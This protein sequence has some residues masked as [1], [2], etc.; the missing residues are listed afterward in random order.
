MI[1][2]NGLSFWGYMF[3][4]RPCTIFSIT[5][6]VNDFSFGAPFKKIKSLKRNFELFIV[7]G[8]SPFAKGCSEC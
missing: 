7:E 8:D 3:E 1:L 5:K 4:G 6:L 2:P